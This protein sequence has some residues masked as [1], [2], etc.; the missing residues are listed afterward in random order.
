MSERVDLH[1]HSDRSSDGDLAPARIIRL[2]R[3]A[4][5]RA[6]SIADHDTVAAY[7]EAVLLGRAEGIEVIPN[8]E[9]TTLFEGREFHLLLPFVKWENPVLRSLVAEV[10]ERRKEEARERIE[11]LQKLGYDIEWEEVLEASGEFPPLGVTIAQ[12]VLSKAGKEGHPLFDKY[13][14]GDSRASAPIFFY[15]DHFM[16]GKPAAV[17]K[18]NVSLLDVLAKAAEIGGVPVL[19]HPGAEFQKAGKKDLSRLKE[20]GLA[21]LEIY[22]TYHDEE[23]ENLYNEM[24]RELDLVPLAGSDFH[25]SVKPHVPFGNVKKGGYWMVEELQKR[26]VR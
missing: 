14:K 7:P 16:E 11:K 4:E 2:A 19:A 1:I 6:I 3:E 12:A 23:Q 18:R 10:A 17:P 20:H 13:M 8:I 26:R 24:A 21:G 25:G 22:S 9:L 15:R 5:Y